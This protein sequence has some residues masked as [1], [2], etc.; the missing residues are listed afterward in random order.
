MSSHSEAP[1]V[2]KPDSNI[3]F[4]SR[5]ISI[6]D[7]SAQI[8]GYKNKSS[9]L[10][11]TLIIT[12]SFLKINLS[13]AISFDMMIEGNRILHWDYNTIMCYFCLSYEMSL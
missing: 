1:F 9:N 10:F 6:C 12:M 11:F 2:G 13:R 5:T 3:R 8:L 4:G 7:A